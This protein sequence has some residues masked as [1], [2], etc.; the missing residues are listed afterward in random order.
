MEV[1]TPLTGEPSSTSSWRCATSVLNALAVGERV[2]TAYGITIHRVNVKKRNKTMV[3]IEVNKHAEI[4][5]E[6]VFHTFPYGA[7][8]PNFKGP[9]ADDCPG[10]IIEAELQILVDKIAELSPVEDIL[11][12]LGLEK[13]KNEAHVEDRKNAFTRAGMEDSKTMT[14][15]ELVGMLVNDRD[16]LTRLL[17][18]VS[19]DLNVVTSNINRR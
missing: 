17:D 13:M 14:L 3:Q 18:T 10:C 19:S 7:F 11:A 9:H 6:Q 5:K 16:R 15:L 4:I 1:L 12:E 2:R 8:I